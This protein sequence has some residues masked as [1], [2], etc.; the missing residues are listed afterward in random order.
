MG[1]KKLLIVDDGDVDWLHAW[2]DAAK[3]APAKIRHSIDVLA[4]MYDLL[5]GSDEIIDSLR[6][7]R[8]LTAEN[9]DQLKK[10]VNVWEGTHHE[11]RS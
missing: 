1:K 8:P 5:Q 3:D 4:E 11:E 10:I 2:V 7:A 6:M 9:I